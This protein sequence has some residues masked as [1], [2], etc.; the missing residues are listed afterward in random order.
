MAEGGGRLAVVAI[1]GAALA[2][3]IAAGWLGGR[4]SFPPPPPPPTFF[5]P[6]RDAVKGE[7]LVHVRP[8][9]RATVS[10]R[11]LQ[12]EAATVHL[13]VEYG[14]PGSPETTR[15]VRVARASFGP[16]VILEGDVPAEYLAMSIKEFQLQSATPEDLRIDSV[17]TTFHCWKFVG[18]SPL[19]GATTI[20]VSD[21]VPVHGVVRVATSK[22]TQWDLHGFGK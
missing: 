13:A 3:G 4:A 18:Q 21:Q 17:G 22:G 5:N 20:W 14:A 11:V 15:E 16:L 7:T 1:A 12:V 10:Y 9:D 8:A 6:L 2:A 19:F